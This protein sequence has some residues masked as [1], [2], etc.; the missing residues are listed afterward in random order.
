MKAFDLRSWLTGF[1]LGFSVKPLPLSTGKTPIAYSYNGTVL[2]KLPEWDKTV[3]PYAVIDPWS[4]GT[5]I[6][7]FTA[8]YETIA[9]SVGPY[10]EMSIEA[11]VLRCIYDAETDTWGESESVENGV[12]VGVAGLPTCAV[13]SNFDVAVTE[14][15]TD[16]YP[17]GMV[18]LAASDPI[19]VYE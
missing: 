4:D 14:S 18:V 7:M 8:D 9:F 6:Y 13:W 12:L 17:V 2:P 3:Y 19:P 5:R 16:E 10:V 11:P 15:G 1:A